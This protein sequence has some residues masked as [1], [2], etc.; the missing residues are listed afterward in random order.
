MH[1]AHGSGSR[2]WEQVKSGTEDLVRLLA[3]W[4]VPWG[5]DGHG[6]GR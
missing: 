5:Q 1:S 2:C 3:K 4:Q 6:R